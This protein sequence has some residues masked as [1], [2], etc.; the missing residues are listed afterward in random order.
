MFEKSACRR[1]KFMFALAIPGIA[2]GISDFALGQVL[3]DLQNLPISDQFSS[4]AF[5][6]SGNGRVI[7]G[8]GTP[9]QDAWIL[10]DNF[11]TTF[12]APGFGPSVARD[13][14]ND[15]SVAVGAA[16][17]GAFR[18]TAAMGGTALGDF[19]GGTGTSFSTAVSAD[20]TI[21]VGAADAPTGMQSHLRAFHWTLTNAATGQGTMTNLGDLPGGDSFSVGAGVSHNGSVVVGGASSAVSLAGSSFELDFEAFRWTQQTGMVALGDLAGGG[22]HS[23]ANAVS[24][25]GSVVVGASTSAASGISDFEA[26]RW[27]EATGMVGLGDLP[28]GNFASTATAVSADGSIIV[29]SSAVAIGDGG[30]DIYAPFIWDAVNGMRDL[31]AVFANLGLTLPELDM[32]DATAVSD[33][34]RTIAG[35]GKSVYRIPAGDLRTEAWIGV[36]PA[37]TVLQGDYNHNGTV[38]AADYTVWRDS[39]GQSGAGLPADGS[40][41][42]VIDANDYDVWKAN[43]GATTG[44]GATDAQSAA[45]PEPA[46]CILL[47]VGVTIGLAR[48][49]RPWARPLTASQPQIPGGWRA[50]D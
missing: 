19:V 13:L 6:V 36:L 49:G 10:D 50:N 45:A 42:E 44:S 46:A 34:G 21:V 15:G 37:P 47:L 25:D 1:A 7:G 2:I 33:D 29:G 27:T 5:A 17:V 22:F 14:S 4:E 41:N 31:R 39:F 38:D 28:G 30:L 32:T 3:L 16:S 24:G 23:F 43:F 26:F 8:R 12:L 35:Y 18:W 11:V 40:G 20:G 9:S 48:R